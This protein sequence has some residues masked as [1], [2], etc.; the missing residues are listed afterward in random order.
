[1]EDR[2]SMPDKKGLEEVRRWW[3]RLISSNP[4]G[5]EIR[6]MMLGLSEDPAS[7]C[8]RSPIETNPS[9]PSEPPFFAEE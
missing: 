9:E 2:A 4:D 7:V 8:L 5:L 6:P 1:M 3:K